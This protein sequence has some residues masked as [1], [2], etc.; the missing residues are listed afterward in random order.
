MSEREDDLRLER[1]L[2]DLL[3]DRDPG[4]APYG[5][6]QRVGSVS[7]T[8]PQRDRRHILAT[9]GG[10]AGLAAVAA[11]LLAVIGRPDGLIAPG[12][13]AAATP[14]P[15]PTF[16]PRIVGPGLVG[17][18]IT[19]EYVV[20]L[21]L[22]VG[23]ALI[24]TAI[25]IRGSRGFALISA[26]ILVGIG[27]AQTLTVDIGPGPI[28]SSRG[29]G[30]TFVAPPAGS[31]AKDVAYITAAPG[32]PFT[33]LVSI[34]NEGSLPIR[35]LGIRD[36]GT[37][38][39]VVAPDITAVW[40]DTTP[41]GASAMEAAAPLAPIDLEPGGYV[42]LYVVGVA[43]PCSFGPTFDPALGSTV[44]YTGLRDL[45]IAYSVYGMPRTTSLSW[46]YDIVEPYSDGPCQP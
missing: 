21:M 19:T 4:P 10:L 32:A 15:N 16:D 17:A 12:V 34:S 31:R 11:V 28:T 36:S 24:G 40:R 3:R 44:G 30:I 46:P 20:G 13:G 7:D 23:G 35:L 22:I 18:G 6:Q 27:V 5:L 39:L 37:P 33:V 14:T 25:R 1:E 8:A 45:E 26:V 29:I 2:R 42:V 41:H 43:G 38:G 9:L